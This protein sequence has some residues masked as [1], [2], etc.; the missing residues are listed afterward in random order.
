MGNA[1]AKWQKAAEDANI[2]AADSLEVLVEFVS[3]EDHPIVG[4]AYTFAELVARKAKL[5]VELKRG[6]IEKKWIGDQLLL[7]LAMAEQDRVRLD[8]QGTILKVGHGASASSISATKLLEQGVT[9]EQ[10]QA[11]TQPGT[12]YSFAQIVPVK[13]AKQ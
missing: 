9:V 1:R 10:I 2:L 11:A 13:E 4:V 6:E 8:E 5:D 3:P 7:A 12:P